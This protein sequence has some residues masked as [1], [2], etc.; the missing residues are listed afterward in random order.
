MGTASLWGLAQL[1][2]RLIAVSGSQEADLPLVYR[3]RSSP[4]SSQASSCIAIKQVLVKAGLGGEPDVRPLSVAAWAGQRIFKESGCIGEVA[5]RL[6]LR[7]LDGAARLIG[8]E[9]P[10]GTSEGG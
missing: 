2:R 10:V 5:R 3:G 9:W 8:W 1:E 6:G 7:S 4:R